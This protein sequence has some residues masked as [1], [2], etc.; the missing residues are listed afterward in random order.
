VLR[1][2]ILA[3]EG[4]VSALGQPEGASRPTV[5]AEVLEVLKGAPG[6]PRVRFAQHGH[7]VVQFEPGDETLLFLIEIARSRE[8]DALG[9]GGSHVWVSLQEHEDE[10][11][12]ES[13][14]RDRLLA[15]AQ[16]YVLAD[17]AASVEIRQ[18]ALRRATLGL[19]T[20]RDPKLAASAVRD[21]VLAPAAPLVGPEERPALEAVLADPTTSMGVRVALLAELERRGIVEGPPH[22]LRLLSADTPPRERATAIRAAA[23]SA[24]GPVHARLIALVADPDVEVAAA[25]AAAL[26]TPGNRDAVAP[27]AGA[28]A[29]ESESVRMAAIRGLGR[30]GTS[31]AERALESAAASHPDPAT[32]R[33]ARAEVRKLGA[34]RPGG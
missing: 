7:G 22:W 23:L 4:E 32:R 20:S 3:V 30:I 11:P 16:A 17:A 5:E 9:R 13:A 12:L 34:V 2:R 15:V 10:Y 26:G 6:A 14:T 24:R 33:R 8:L 1:A 31:E 21:L 28:L 19:L 18:A 27:L 25:A 29:R